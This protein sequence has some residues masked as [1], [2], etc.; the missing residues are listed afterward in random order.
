MNSLDVVFGLYAAGQ[1]YKGFRVGFKRMLYDT[2]KW[3]IVFG[4]SAFIYKFFIPKLFELEAYTKLA[5][6]I[7]LK[8]I[9]FIQNSLSGKENFLSE[10]MLANINNLKADRFIL[11][12]LLLIIISV[13]TRLLI[14]GSFWNSDSDGRIL[15][16]TFGVVKACIYGI[17]AMLIISAIMN[18]IN[19]EAFYKWQSES[20]I[21]NYINLIF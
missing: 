1:A 5:S 3:I 19:P 2:V 17:I 8:T 4:S 7:N 21:L 12:V 20:A 10:L 16:A 18:V 11:F 15:G 6:D 13:I 9:E 14:V